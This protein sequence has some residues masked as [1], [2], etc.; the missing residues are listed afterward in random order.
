MGINQRDT[1]GTW[2]SGNGMVTVMQE[3]LN[4]I[5]W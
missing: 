3:N 4:K 5:K 2:K 1:G